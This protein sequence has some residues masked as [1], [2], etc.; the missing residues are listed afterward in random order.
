MANSVYGK[1]KQNILNG[2]INFSSNQFKVLLVKSSLYSINLNTHE[3]VS[4]IPVLAIVARSSSLTNVTNTLGVVDGNDLIIAL[5]GNQSF[6][7]VIL[8]QNGTTDANSK[9]IFYIDTA[10]GLPYPGSL[11][12]INVSIMWSNNSIKILSL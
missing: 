5:N 8:Y 3:N 10:E 2:N 9:L 6:D 4:D 12:S 11:D 1:A 7:A